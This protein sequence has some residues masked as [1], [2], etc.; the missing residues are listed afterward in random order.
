MENENT[1]YATGRR[2]NAIAR[3]WVKPGTGQITVNKKPLDEYFKLE[4]A[5]QLLR[6]PLELT[7][8]LRHLS[9][10]PKRRNA[11]TDL[12]RLAILL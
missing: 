8:N 6:Q 1:Y 9:D 3:T 5:K 11:I 12:H 7:E 4:T 10:M 2:K